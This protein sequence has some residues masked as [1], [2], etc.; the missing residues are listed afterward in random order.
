MDTHSEQ[1]KQTR[2]SQKTKSNHFCHRETPA[3]GVAIQLVG[4]ANLKE[5]L[6]TRKGSDRMIGRIEAA[7]TAS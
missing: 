7:G 3:G 1:G 5:P 4:S 6:K 2:L